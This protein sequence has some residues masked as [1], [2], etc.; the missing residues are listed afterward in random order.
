MRIDEAA[1]VARHLDPPDRAR[2]VHIEWLITAGCGPSSHFDAARARLVDH[3]LSTDRPA[4]PG[5]PDVVVVR[6]DDPREGLAHARS[7]APDAATVVVT[8]STDAGALV[9]AVEAGAIGCLVDG[10]YDGQ[11]L[12]LAITRGMQRR[13]SWSAPTVAA[14]IESL[15]P[16]RGRP[17]VSRCAGL[18]PRQR[19]IMELVSRGLGNR[20]IAARLFLAEKTVRNHLHNIYQ[21][22]EVGGRT[23][24]MACWNRSLRTVG[25]DLTV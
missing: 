12:E 11:A 24:A 4:N 2:R 8:T 1:R 10:H 9:D 21:A 18:S 16:T 3:H 6:C 7:V 17:P 22:M 23:A 20:E 15:L 14:V 25:P 19:E 13:P 5:S